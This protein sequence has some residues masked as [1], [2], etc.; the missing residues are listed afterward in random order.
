LNTLPEEKPILKETPEMDYQFSH[1]GYIFEETI[2][3]FDIRWK[4]SFHAMLI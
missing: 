3:A 2:Y 1:K 4:S